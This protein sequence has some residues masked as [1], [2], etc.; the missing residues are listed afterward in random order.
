MQPSKKAVE[1][2]KQIFEKKYGKKLSNQ[3]A[4]KSASNLLNFYK[5]LYD[6]AVKE[7]IKKEKL[8]KHPKGFHL[9]DGVYNCLVCHRQVT[10][11][12][13][14]WDLL[15]PKCLNCQ[16]AIDKK[17]IPKYI[18]ENRDSWYAMWELKSKLGI[19]HATARKMIREGKLKARIIKD[20]AGRDYFYVFLA[21]DNRKLLT[22]KCQKN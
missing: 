13:S 7:E 9:D 20:E 11:K 10:G 8:K 14:W 22:K 17:I 2:F 5:V 4:C 1:E 19:H 15:G 21:E 18:C 3:E 6:C 16:S 12:E